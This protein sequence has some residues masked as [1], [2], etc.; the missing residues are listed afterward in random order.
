MQRKLFPFAA[1]CAALALLLAIASW[2]LREGEQ[3]A[4]ATS[5]GVELEQAEELTSPRESSA[6]TASPRRAEAE[7]VAVPEAPAAEPSA[8]ARFEIEGV[9]VAA[10]DRRPL[11]GVELRHRTPGQPLGILLATTDAEGRFRCALDARADAPARTLL[12]FSAPARRSL[13]QVIEGLAPAERRDLG[14]LE[15]AKGAELAGRVT[16]PS[17]A[18]IAG[19]VLNAAGEH[20]QSDAEGRFLFVAG[21]PFGKLALHVM[22]G[23]FCYVVRELD[24]PLESELVLVLQRARSI[25]GYVLDESRKPIEGVVLYADASTIPRLATSDAAGRFSLFDPLGQET[26]THLH[27]QPG[28]TEL[29]RSKDPIPWGARDVVVELRRTLGLEIEVVDAETG[30]P[31]E[32]YGVHFLPRTSRPQKGS[33]KEMGL[34]EGGKLRLNRV[35]RGEMRLWIVPEDPRWMPHERQEVLIGE[36]GAP[37][38]RLALERRPRV[39]V[40]L[41]DDA[42]A[43]V[44]GA[45]I[46]LLRSP[47]DRPLHPLDLTALDDGGLL[48][49]Q[50]GRP[51]LLDRATSD[52]AG[53]TALH[54]VLDR[55]QLTPPRTGLP[56][57]VRPQLFVRAEKPGFAPTIAEMPFAS[58]EQQ[59]R[60]VLARAA[61]LRGRLEPARALELE[62]KLWLAPEGVVFSEAELVREEARLAVDADG[63]FF[64]EGLAPGAVE[65]RA[66]F[67][68]RWIA[69]PLAQIELRSG[70]VNEVVLDLS[71]HL[72]ASASVEVSGAGAGQIVQLL[73]AT[74][75]R[76][77]GRFIHRRAEA[78]LDASGRGELARVPPGT[79]D[80]VLRDPPR[81]DPNRRD[82][83]TL[84]GTATFAPDERRALRFE[85]H[86][87]RLVIQVRRADG[88][89]PPA[90]GSA[91]LVE[92]VLTHEAR[93]DPEGRLVFEPAPTT[94]FELNALRE[95]HPRSGS[96]APPPG[97]DGWTIEVTLRR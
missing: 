59:L 47:L 6:A 65:V 71:A 51:A 40:Q 53:R 35:E 19:A 39:E 16:D 7:T 9:V 4:E 69:Q 83:Q 57:E 78:K 15:L 89:L 95:R 34:H 80:V 14:T 27:V 52:A 81:F 23:G 68:T 90:G 1:A 29:W 26:A 10:E 36:N 61:A 50:I 58:G 64:A 96:Y 54:G 24:L 79:Y 5:P 37:P 2:L 85:Y 45:E 11:A 13:P 87:R 63:H 43:S 84:L 73:E 94:P 97:N 32:R 77:G 66:R 75:D 8:P 91:F 18:P 67:G 60:V 22:A 86:P 62:P 46:E 49:S 28:I 12:V 44:G 20:A 30:S 21:F 74:L 88:S 33:L 25:E 72:F 31:I 3:A 55:P 38:Q 70:A 42:G 92:G 41:V 93:F 17:G 82:A 56:P 76:G 48:R